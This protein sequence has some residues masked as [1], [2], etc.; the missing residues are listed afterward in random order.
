MFLFQA[1]DQKI[2][3]KEAA[4]KAKLDQDIGQ[5]PSPGKVRLKDGF[6]DID[7]VVDR[8]EAGQDKGDVRQEFPRNHAAGNKAETHR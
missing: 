3:G 8:K 7:K 1:P 6:I 2:Q 4:E 5:D